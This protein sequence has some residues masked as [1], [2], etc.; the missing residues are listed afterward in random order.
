MA[1]KL[2]IFPIIGKSFK[3]SFVE[4]YGSLGFT[5]L[6]SLIWFGCYLPILFIVGAFLLRKMPKPPQPGEIM[7]LVMVFLFLF[8]IWNSFGAG[9]IFSA[10]YGLYQE[11]KEDY[12]S[13]KM[14]FRILKKYYWL[15]AG[16]WGIFS[17]AFSML[18]LN[19]IIA[20]MGRQVVVLVAGA[21]SVYMLFFIL[22]M[23]FYFNPLIQLGNSWK[24]VIR[25]SFLLVL[26]NF[27]LSFWFILV[28]TVLLVL[29]IYIPFIFVMLYGAMLIYFSDK[30]F[31]AVYNKYDS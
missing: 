20:L 6:V 23:S 5:L 8:C 24:K 15:S 22:L 14:Y 4:L 30:G 2:P 11:R 3:E 27:G 10:T 9:P 21:I 29:S 13:V 28:L 16:V 26:D 31:G 25:K 17:L 18:F 12:A 19:I 1:T 7:F